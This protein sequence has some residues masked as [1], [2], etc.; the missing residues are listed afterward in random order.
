MLKIISIISFILVNLLA[1][2]RD[3][4]K[5][6]EFWVILIKLESNNNSAAIGDGGRAIGVAQIHKAY[7]QDAVEYNKTI[8]GEY[9]NCFDINYSKKI[10]Y[11]YLLR[12]SKSNNWEEW[13]RL[14]NS[15]SSWK[16]KKNLTDNYWNKF[17]KLIDDS[18][19][20]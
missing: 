19:S 6:D 4:E 16:K 13:A 10:V 18:N 15:G 3:L 20:K 17:K 7:W 8:G 12:Y 5:F 9:K 1:F 11:A 2:S 14:H